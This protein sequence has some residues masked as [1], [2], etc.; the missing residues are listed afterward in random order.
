MDRLDPSHVTPRV[1]CV[2]ILSEPLVED[3]LPI[4]VTLISLPEKREIVATAR[5]IINNTQT[6]STVKDQ[7]VNMVNSLPPDGCYGYGPLLMIINEHEKYYSIDN[8]PEHVCLF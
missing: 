8:K 3:H 1:K 5:E 6:G 2:Y 4:Q 7:S